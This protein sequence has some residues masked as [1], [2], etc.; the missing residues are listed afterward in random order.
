VALPLLGLFYSLRGAYLI[1]MGREFDY[2]LIGP[3]VARSMG[4]GGHPNL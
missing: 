1:E 2:P 3:M 4:F